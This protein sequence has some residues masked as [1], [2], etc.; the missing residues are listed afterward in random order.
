VA[1]A[2]LFFFS[3]AT[4]C[5]GIL[6]LASI[7]YLNGRILLKNLPHVKS[8]RPKDVEKQAR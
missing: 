7:I 6:S 1:I 2:T 5:A 8:I 3:Q 4:N